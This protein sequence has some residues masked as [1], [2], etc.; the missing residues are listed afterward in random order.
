MVRALLLIVAATLAVPAAAQ[1]N[2]ERRASPDSTLA[3]GACAATAPC[4][5]D[6]AVHGA[7]D[8]DQV[9]VAPGFYAVATPLDPTAAI[10]IHGVPGQP[11]PRLVG[12]ARCWK[13]R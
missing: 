3:S 2:S 6:F 11:R 8:G 4:S 12:A 10:D 9:V 1:A 13:R 7:G 5:L